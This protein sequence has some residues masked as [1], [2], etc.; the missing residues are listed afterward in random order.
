MERKTPPKKE[1]THKGIA[2]IRPA[3][4]FEIIQQ[5]GDFYPPLGPVEQ[6]TDLLSS[7]MMQQ[8]VAEDEIEGAE[9]GKVVCVSRSQRDLRIP[10]RQFP[11]R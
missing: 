8:M 10:R 6:T 2:K 3:G 5:V 1:G 7:E 11:G 9:S 4:T